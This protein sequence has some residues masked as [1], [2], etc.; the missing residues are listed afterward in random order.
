MGQHKVKQYNREQYLEH[1]PFC[2]YC[3][4]KAKTTDHIPNRAYFTQRGWPDGHEFPCCK[5]CNDETRIDELVVAFLLNLRLVDNS[6]QIEEMQI[7]LAHGIKNN[8]PEIVQEWGVDWPTSA[9]GR[10]RAF[11]EAFGEMGDEMRRQ[12]F[13]MIDIGPLTKQRLN[14]FVTK[15]AKTL[16]YKHVGRILD[17][18]IFPTWHNIYIDS[19][20]V[21]QKRVKNAL[22]FADNIEIPERNKKLTS[23]QF[24]YRYRCDPDQGWLFASVVFSEQFMFDLC[25]VSEPGMDWILQ[26]AGRPEL[27]LDYEVD[28]FRLKFRPEGIDAKFPH[29]DFPRVKATARR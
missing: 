11:R 9:S 20:E 24:F 14:R 15:L 29:T 4:A 25:V 2:C 1:N 17:G 6:P 5:Q 19:Q 10:K 26:N 28:R 18:Y 16:Y 23:D 21:T 22:T 12:N 27:K 8:A 7:K 3:G 13:G